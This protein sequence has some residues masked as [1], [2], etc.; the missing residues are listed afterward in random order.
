MKKETNKQLER[1]L[2][3]A[4][5]IVK[6]KSEDPESS[7][8]DKIEK[9]KR[10]VFLSR[11]DLQIVLGADEETVLNLE[12]FCSVTPVI[13]D[14]HIKYSLQEIIENI[15]YGK[16]IIDGK[17]KYELLNNIQMYHP[18]LAELCLL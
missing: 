12:R 17:S 3:S 8:L 18:E 6:N 11:R 5:L 10:T 2:T 4:L 9:E 13:E 1:L 14:N 15:R 7:L 16:L